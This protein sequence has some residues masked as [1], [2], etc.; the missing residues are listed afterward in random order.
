LSATEHA[1][2]NFGFLKPKRFHKDATCN[3]GIAAA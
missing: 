1:T 2:D 3:P